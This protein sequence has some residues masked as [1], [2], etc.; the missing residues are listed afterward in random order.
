MEPVIEFASSA[1]C[2]VSIWLNTRRNSI[3]W[4][5]GLVSVALA[6]WV[7]L[8]S[9]LFAEC[10]LQV[11]YFLSGIYGWWQWETGKSNEGSLMVRKIPVSALWF[12]LLMG[13]L[14]FGL[15]FEFLKSISS[16]SQPFLDSLITAFSIVA[17][18]WLARR[19]IE[20]WILWILINLISICLYV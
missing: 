8:Q 3:G 17:Q 2:V 9:G 16:S 20:N 5:I 1:T 7:Y 15:L 18:I 14:G 12:S 13:T 6:S 4:P 19:W 11:F 10:G